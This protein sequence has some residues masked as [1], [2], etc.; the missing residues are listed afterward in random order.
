MKNIYIFFILFMVL[1]K[2]LK[3][4]GTIAIIT[5]LAILAYNLFSETVSKSPT[6]EINLT[7]VNLSECFKTPAY[8]YNYTIQKFFSRDEAKEYAHRCQEEGSLV[9]VCFDNISFLSNVSWK[10]VA[11]FV[12]IKGKWVGVRFN[13]TPFFSDIISVVCVK[14]NPTY[15][16]YNCDGIIYINNTTSIEPEVGVDPLEPFINESLWAAKPC[17]IMKEILENHNQL[18][19]KYAG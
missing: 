14:K 3:T 4:G 9:G 6:P 17:D 2:V 10:D 13:E 5:I 12:K 8:T 19:L 7:E 1:E 16:V 15:F 18:V 11:Y